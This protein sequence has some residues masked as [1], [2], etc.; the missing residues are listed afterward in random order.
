MCI[1]I[2]PIPKKVNN[3]KGVRA[4][5]WPTAPLF[6]RLIDHVRRSYAEVENKVDEKEVFID[7]VEVHDL[8]DCVE[9]LT[10]AEL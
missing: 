8:V 7:A 4:V 2:R 1:L 6:G 10:L 9:G 3:L 5:P